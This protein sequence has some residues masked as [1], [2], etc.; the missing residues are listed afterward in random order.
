VLSVIWRSL[1]RV[2]E[3][4]DQTPL[5]GEIHRFPATAHNTL[6]CGRQA[7]Y[8]STNGLPAVTPE[9]DTA[10]RDLERAGMTLSRHP[11]EAGVDWR[12]TLPG[13]E[14]VEG[15][16]PG[17]SGLSPPTEILRLIEGTTAGKELVAGPIPRSQPREL[18]DE[19]T[20][21]EELT[22]QLVSGSASHPWR[23]G[24]DAA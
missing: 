13:G 20:R 2:V 1:A 17:T 18:P 11:S 10:E 8:A 9:Y 7:L 14:Q 21:F 3:I 19:Y 16:E 22:R 12:L 5:P 15:W 24:S 6:G 23:G 4:T